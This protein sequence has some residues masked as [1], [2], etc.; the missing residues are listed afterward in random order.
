MDII[1]W[2]SLYFITATPD[3]IHDVYRIMVYKVG[4]APVYYRMPITFGVG[5]AD[6]PKRIEELA[7]KLGLI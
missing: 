3:E 6:D 1:I 5:V 7:L 2:A 4:Y